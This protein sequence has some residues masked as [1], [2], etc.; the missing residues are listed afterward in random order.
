MIEIDDFVGRFDNR[1]G[2]FLVNYE[3]VGLP[4]WGLSLLLE[5]LDETPVSA[6]EEFFLKLL[7]VG[8]DDV[9]HMSDILGLDQ[10]IIKGVASDLVREDAI[11]VSNGK[12]MMAKAGEKIVQ[13]ASLVRPIERSYVLHYDAILKRPKSYEAYQL[14]RP[15]DLKEQGVRLINPSPNKTPPVEDLSIHD[16]ESALHRSVG[17]GGKPKV[18]RIKGVAGKRVHFQKAIML[19]YKAVVGAEIQVAFAIDRRLSNEHEIEFAR[20]NG[21]VRLGIIGGISEPS[22]VSPV[23]ELLGVDEA[24]S[25]NSEAHRNYLSNRH[26]YKDI[27]D[28][29]GRLKELQAGG[30]H[31]KQSKTLEQKLVSEIEK[32]EAQ[33]IKA[34]VRMVAVYEHPEY[35]WDAFTTAKERILIISPWITKAVVDQEFMRALRLKL[36]EGV[37]I[38]IGYGLDERESEKPLV[39][40]AERELLEEHKKY[41]RFFM[42][43]LGDTHAKVLIKDSE[44]IITTSFNWLSFRGNPHKKFREEWG[45]F[46]GVKDLVDEQ[47]VKLEERLR[48]VRS[49]DAEVPCE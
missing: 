35:L 11:H 39:S 14:S 48:G 43:R 33:S 17:G 47:F 29:K 42:R 44:Y 31:D 2:F 15:V 32:L 45:T 49:I 10:K 13:T 5:T 36:H 25:I 27:S 26:V 38:Y 22:N 1:D 20:Q 16:V 34:K 9:E 41:E 40:S 3:I 8:I 18:L 12:F 4:V 37:S 23:G 21:P 7:N 30:V 46:I 19:I 24:V 28:A 6:T